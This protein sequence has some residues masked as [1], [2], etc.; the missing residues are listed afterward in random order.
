MKKLT[1][2]LVVALF[3]AVIALTV[4]SFKVTAAGTGA[5]ANCQLNA[6]VKK[7][8]GS[9]AVT[10]P[11]GAS[12]SGNCISAEA[13]VEQVDTDND[14][15]PDT[16]VNCVVT[17]FYTCQAQASGGGANQGCGLMQAC[18]GQ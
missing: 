15:T 1:R 5:C 18:G 12:A 3:A 2:L 17:K 10:D 9:A 6:T 4:T 13:S 7:C 16:N 11:A 8:N 14:G